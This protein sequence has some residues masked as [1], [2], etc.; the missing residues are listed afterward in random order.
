MSRFPSFLS[1][2]WAL[3]LLLPVGASTPV[4]RAELDACNVVWNSPSE[5]SR[6]SMPIGNGEI[7]LN[8][9]VEPSG[10]LLF[11]IGKTD[12]WDE[13]M[14]LVK[15][16]GVRM[17][18]S[19]SLVK[20]GQPFTQTLDLATGRILI[21]TPEQEVVVWVDANH[22]VVQVD[23][24][25]LNGQPVAVTASSHLWRT[26]G[27]VDPGYN[28]FPAFPKLAHADTIL[29]A[30]SGQIGW[31]HANS[32]S[33]WLQ[34]LAF[35]KL[36][37]GEIGN[38]PLRHRVFGAILRGDGFH[39]SS[40][41][42]LVT[43][44]PVQSYSLGVHVLTQA[45]SD[46]AT[47]QAAVEAQASGTQS[48]PAS[49]R[50]AAHGEWWNE[51]W[52]RSWIFLKGP[53][54]A[55]PVS[56][57]P[58]RVGKASNG[59][60]AF[61][62]SISDARIDGRA[63]SPQEVAS[64]AGAARAGA[65]GIQGAGADISSG[66][67][68][69]AWVNPGANDSGRILDRITASTSDGVLLDAYP[70]SSLRWI[71]GKQSA[72]VS[73]CLVP[74]VW[75]HV[76][77]TADAAT[78]GLR[79]YRNGVLLKEV[80]NESDAAKVTRAYT[81]QR[82]VNAC[83]GRGTFPIKFNG[84]LFTADTN[85][86]AGQDADYRRWGGCYWFMN[87]R[88]I[89]WSMPM[90]G[91]LDMMLPLFHLYRDLLPIR[92]KATRAYFNHDGAYFPETMTIWGTFND[93]NYG[94]NRTGKP[95]GLT[96]NQHIRYYWQGGIELIALMLD[97]YDHTKDEAFRED[98]LMPLAKEILTFFNRH[99][100]R[101]GD[102]KIR[103]DPAQALECHFSAVNPAPEVSGLHSVLPRL[104]AIGGDPA[105]RAEWQ[106]MLRDLPPVPTKVDG[107]GK[108]VLLPGLTYSAKRQSEVP[109]LYPVFPYRLYTAT[110]S[111][112]ALEIGRSTWSGSSKKNNGWGQTPI[113]AAMLGLGDEARTYVVGR[114]QNPASGFRF[115]AFWGPNDDWMPD[116]DQGTI[117]MTALQR[118]LMQ[119]E[120]NE[121]R[122]LPAWPKDWD[123]KFK[124]HA[125]G[126]TTLEGVVIGGKVT[127][128]T[129][130]PESRRGDVVLVSESLL[131][132]SA[133]LPFP[134]NS[135]EV[136]PDPV[137]AGGD[138]DSW[139]LL[140][141][142]APLATRTG[143]G[144]SHF[145]TFVEPGIYT[146]KLV[147]VRQGVPLSDTLVVTVEGARPEDETV[148]GYAEWSQA[149]PEEKRGALDDADG[150]GVSNFI[151]FVMGSG[152]QESGDAAR[153]SLARDDA[154]WR[155]LFPLS[156]NL[157]ARVY[158]YLEESPDLRGW[159]PVSS[160]SFLKTEEET[161]FLLRMSLPEEVAE[162][163]FYRLSA[164][165]R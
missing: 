42:E 44:A 91:D 47:W 60:S 151:E 87:T 117:L 33:P 94:T 161:R 72:S 67:T 134:V 79:I 125:P 124:L 32:A 139:S 22:P 59:G 147:A 7:A 6:G 138:S 131:P 164:I 38:D 21:T 101:G 61:A 99:W 135:L 81:L 16:G 118:M 55:V 159:V 30:K 132:P 74:G 23:G 27:T 39:S 143:Q 63:L 98:T 36:D 35:Q 41:R 49:A 120:G 142:P 116:Q 88:L 58:W 128:L 31:Y 105:T 78:G 96:D 152:A 8:V 2:L 62:G 123:A 26:D 126:N 5:D 115:P 34:N 45:E 141:G 4:P 153:L 48:T 108:E 66:L 163:K 13:N 111:K 56:V 29:P 77:A 18:F 107:T 130:T 149:L 86:A 97:Y 43:D 110:K 114:V 165:V 68:V 129:V 24:R 90:A 52:N 133:S 119:H 112:A 28:N 10:D 146:V 57:Q 85:P 65:T 92:K 25:S 51:F 140:E 53:V 148:P 3:G 162:R 14:R 137:A 95:D 144:G 69:S 70:G 93:L 40:D 127:G 156:K 150:D 64:L 145:L 12:A 122:L 75:Q 50:M 19:P 106:E 84:S 136:S 104:L 83:A 103:F 46:P 20:E 71:V 9:W 11:Y 100:P 76:A 154:G 15:V 73:N 121:I 109:E 17:K 158:P 82:F 89:Y 54:T 102:G 160:P 37:T 155:I 113:M 157:P 80:V 1:G